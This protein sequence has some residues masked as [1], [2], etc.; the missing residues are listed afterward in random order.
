MSCFQAF[1]LSL[2]EIELGRR[3]GCTGVSLRE[4]KGKGTTVEFRARWRW[5]IKSGCDLDICWTYR[6]ESQEMK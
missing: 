5:W 6:R 1:F 2:E 4:G 3:G